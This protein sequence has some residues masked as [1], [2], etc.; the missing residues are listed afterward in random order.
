[1]N[2]DYPHAIIKING[3]GDNAYVQLE[4]MKED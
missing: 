1:M 4:K 2:T 3:Y